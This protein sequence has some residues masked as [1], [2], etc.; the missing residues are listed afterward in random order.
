MHSHYYEGVKFFCVEKSH[1]IKKHQIFTL[2]DNSANIYFRQHMGT[3]Y[4]EDPT[5]SK[6]DSDMKLKKNYLLIY[7]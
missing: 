2:L 1:T 4:L 7:N 6:A 3:V 5:H